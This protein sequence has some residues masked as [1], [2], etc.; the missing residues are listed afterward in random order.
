MQ[1]RSVGRA[2]TLSGTVQLEDVEWHDGRRELNVLSDGG[3]K[4][5][6]GPPEG[7]IPPLAMTEV[8]VAALPGPSDGREPPRTPPQGHGCFTEYYSPHFGVF[9]TSGNGGGGGGGS[10]TGSSRGDPL[11]RKDPWKGATATTLSYT[12][13]DRMRAG[14]AGGDPSDDG[15]GS[16]SPGHKF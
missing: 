15:G 5:L 2:F 3:A 4:A 9:A 1:M 7:R 10:D 16:D 6:P 13:G 12:T 8:R 14:G 11:Q